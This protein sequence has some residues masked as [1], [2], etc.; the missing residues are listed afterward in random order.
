M[1]E[2]ARKDLIVPIA[3][4]IDFCYI[5]PCMNQIISENSR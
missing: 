4:V 5:N 3:I 1:A 2:T